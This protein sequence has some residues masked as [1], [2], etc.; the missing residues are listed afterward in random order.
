MANNKYDDNKYMQLVGINPP[1][2]ETI[3]TTYKSGKD[4]Y[5]KSAKKFLKGRK[6]NKSII[7][8]A[9][10]NVY[11]FPVFVSDS[12]QLDFA[13]A[14]C[15]LLEQ[16]YASQLEVAISMNPIISHKDAE[17]GRFL[18]KYMTNT[19]KY[20]EYADMSFAHEACH[21]ELT[22]IDGST[23]FEFDVISIE[24][25]EAEIINEHVSY[26]ELGEFDHF[27]TEADTPDLPEIITW[28][29]WRQIYNPNRNPAREADERQN[30]A[31]YRQVAD[32]V[33]N[34]KVE[35]NQQNEDRRRQ[36]EDAAERR[37]NAQNDRA[38]AQERRAEA[39]EQ[40][41]QA[42][43]RR[44]EAK[45]QRD[46]LMHRRQLA[47]LGVK[48]RKGAIEGN[49]VMRELDK[50]NRDLADINGAPSYVGDV[51]NK[52]VK[53]QA[54]ATKAQKDVADINDS[55]YDNEVY[56]RRRKLSAEA[57]MKET[58]KNWQLHRY[59]MEKN[60]DAR[61]RMAR[62]PEIMDE[63]KIRKLNTMK[64]YLMKVQL[65]VK[66]PD[67]DVTEY[68]IEFLCGV[69][70]NC[71]L[72][73]SSTLPDV[74]KYPIKEMNELTRKIK[75]KAG[76]LKFFKDIVFN[77]KEKKQTAIDSKNPERKWYRKLYQLAHMK[78]DSFVAKQI[79]GNSR[80][81]LIPNATLIISENDVEMVKS[82]TEIDLL[83][84]STAAKFCKELFMMALI[85]VDQDRESLKM[86]IP[87]THNDYV[88]Y[89]LAAV[90]K[91]LAELSTAGTKTR[92]LFKLLG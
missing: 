77:I 91:M 20:L 35:R 63:T 78:G 47:D 38:Q 44:A 82:E 24:D 36:Y 90:Q 4:L 80:T 85:V 61:E 3:A 5:G 73:K 59:Q 23:V 1:D 29:Q 56:N 48:I 52:R 86:M 49:K 83:K 79:S 37:A 75:Y 69:K 27:F 43:E 76:E 66:N 88:V 9:S 14:T 28:D 12:V 7:G 54:D 46:I 33:L 30:Y 87:D 8:M 21:N 40:R 45:E 60:K 26:G 17:D 18:S 10:K 55:T 58:D 65:R 74:A 70:V 64:P 16:L 84:G 81:G 89:S 15:S 39:Q 50:L 57:S 25:D 62:A 13:E 22:S 71:R 72:I 34:E 53:N 2:A 31:R 11:E 32:A 67:G 41:D 42:Q 51:G 92:D 19:S 6:G 68:P